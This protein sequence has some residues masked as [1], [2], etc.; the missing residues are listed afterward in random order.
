MEQYDTEDCQRD[1]LPTATWPVSQVR[2]KLR[3]FWWYLLRRELR[4]KL[5]PVEH[6]PAAPPT[7]AE[8]VLNLEV[9]EWVRVKSRE[10]IDATLDSEHKFRGLRFTPEMYDFCNQPLMVMRKVEQIRVEHHGLRH[11][12]NTVILDGAICQGGSQGGS[13]GCDRAC[14]HFWRE[15]WLERDH[16]GG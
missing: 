11:I 16:K 15:V 2:R 6:V 9:G 1:S 7:T 12:R 8:R 4:Q 13:L 5:M 14:Y 3:V 10:E